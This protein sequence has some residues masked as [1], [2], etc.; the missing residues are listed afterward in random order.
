MKPLVPIIL[1]RRRMLKMKGQLKELEELLSESQNVSHKAQCELVQAHLKRYLGGEEVPGVSLKELKFHLQTCHS[2]L[3]VVARRKQVLKA[4]LDQKL[5]K[6]S[7]ELAGQSLPRTLGQKA[8]MK[9][10][11]LDTILQ[12]Q[13]ALSEK[14]EQV[15][16]PTYTKDP[17][18]RKQAFQQSNIQFFSK[19]WKTLTLFGALGIFLVLISHV[20]ADP[21]TLLGKKVIEPQQSAL[22]STTMLPE[23]TV[24]NV[25]EQ[26][27]SAKGD[28]GIS[29]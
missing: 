14:S 9:T 5:E 8:K 23:N 7:K 6:E 11:L 19:N 18:S 3:G 29:W 10:L 20:M 25:I 24:Q 26:D 12:K 27:P 4:L 28:Q 22:A 17:S 15:S 21:T 2:C 13:S 16:L 1:N